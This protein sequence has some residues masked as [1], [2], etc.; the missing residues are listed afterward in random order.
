MVVSE[1]GTPRDEVRRPGFDDL[2][3]A[4]ADARGRAQRTH[5]LVLVALQGGRFVVGGH[6]APLGPE[7]WAVFPEGRAALVRSEVVKIDYPK[8]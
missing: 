7:H 2:A 4:L 1:P 3:S 8:T 6:G 5:S